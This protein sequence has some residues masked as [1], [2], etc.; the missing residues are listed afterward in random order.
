M[1]TDGIQPKSN[2][3]NKG[4]EEEGVLSECCLNLNIEPDKPWKSGRQ[5]EKLRL[6]ETVAGEESRG[7]KRW[8]C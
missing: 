3:E 8:G 4:I 2:S 5:T 1:V 6:S 7:A